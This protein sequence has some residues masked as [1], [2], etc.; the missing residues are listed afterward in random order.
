MNRQ[1]E[2][3][4]SIRA[5]QSRVA[6]GIWKTLFHSVIGGVLVVT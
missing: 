2:V 5:L 1:Y 4:W 6:G 3:I